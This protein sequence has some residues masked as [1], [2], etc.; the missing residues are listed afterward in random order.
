MPRLVRWYIKT[1]F[2]WF[3]AALAVRLVVASA[4]GTIVSR[5][6]PVVWH[7]LLVGWLTQL[8]FGVAHW[9]FPTAP[10]S[11]KTYLRGN[12]T[13]IWIVWV[14]LNAGLLVRV[15]AEPLQ[16]AHPASWAG[17][18]LL[19]CVEHLAASASTPPYFQ[20]HV[21]CPGS[22]SGSCAWR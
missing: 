4:S 8:I 10:T 18:T 11:G 2:I 14:L 16:A 17:L 1:A 15:V 6:N 22:A 7:M 9:M 5:L 19:F 3:V 13:L 20:E 12:E 21:K